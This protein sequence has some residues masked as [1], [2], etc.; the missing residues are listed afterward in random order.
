MK[1]WKRDYYEKLLARKASTETVQQYQRQIE[2]AQKK[3][4]ELQTKCKHDKFEVMFYSWRPGAMQPSHI[5]V[6]C[7]KFL[8][9]ATEEESKTLWSTFYNKE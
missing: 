6:K 2:L 5:C 9:D 3:I 1:I 8:G 4:E 7:D